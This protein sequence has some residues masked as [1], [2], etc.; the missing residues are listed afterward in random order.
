[1]ETDLL[2]ATSGHFCSQECDVMTPVCLSVAWTTQSRR[3]TF[4]A[5]CKF[6]A[7]G[8]DDRYFQLSCFVSIPLNFLFSF[9][10]LSTWIVFP[11]SSIQ[12]SSH[13]T[14]ADSRR[15]S[16]G[17]LNRNRYS[18]R[19]HETVEGITSELLIA[20]VGRVDSGIYRFRASNAFGTDQT[21][22][23][24]KIQGNAMQLICI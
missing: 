22:V 23:K 2:W 4:V 7:S 3:Q 18:A 8:T 19:Q 15:Q 9:F 16:V 5:L 6:T 1:M 11:F 10:S 13:S 21:T 14:D 17:N 12:C 20:D 24:R